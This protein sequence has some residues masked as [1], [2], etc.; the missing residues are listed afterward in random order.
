MI[1]GNMENLLVIPDD[2]RKKFT[3]FDGVTSIGTVWPESTDS[4]NIWCADGLMA[5]ELLD[6]I[7]EQID[8]FNI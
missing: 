7:G 2:D 3:V 1:E 4:G 6:Q 5:R 8:T